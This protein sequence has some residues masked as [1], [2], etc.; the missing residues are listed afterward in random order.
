MTY[1]RYW[2]FKNKA[3]YVIFT[4]GHLNVCSILYWITQLTLMV[5]AVVDIGV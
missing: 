4:D 1:Q 5:K 2:V 3:E